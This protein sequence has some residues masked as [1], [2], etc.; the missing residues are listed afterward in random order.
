[1]KT[2]GIIS[3]PARIS[4]VNGKFIDHEQTAIHIEDRGFQFADGVY[5]VIL[6]HNQKLVDFDW[7]ME[8]LNRSL[9]E[10]GISFAYEKTDLRQAFLMLFEKNHLSEGFVYLQIT[11]GVAPRIQIC[12]DGLKPTVVA[13]VS[14]SKKI[15]DD[16]F[17]AGF[18]A[19][20]HPDIRWLRCDIK[21]IGLLGSAMA[22]HKAEG[23]GAAEAVLH[24]DGEVTEGSFSNIFI[25]NKSG[26]LQT[27]PANNLILCGITRNRIIELAK[28]NNI[29]TKEREFSLEE[30]YSAREVFLSSSTLMLR[31]IVRIDD[32]KIGDGKVG[33]LTK[34]LNQ[35]YKEFVEL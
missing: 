20:T 6:F 30:L 27:H 19:I 35:W 8:R 11:R 1:M 12:P 25:V 34:K 17:N 9:R 10:I 2:E 33:I 14:K 13:T 16:E 22:R 26:D 21:S 28:Q 4:Y 23:V 7:H 15:S 32:K 5:E 24:R 3:R 31:P 18:S 29:K